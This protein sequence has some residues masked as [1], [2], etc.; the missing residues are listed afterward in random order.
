MAD[1]KSTRREE[2]VLF[3]EGKV[4]VIIELISFRHFEER[5]FRLMDFFTLAM[6]EIERAIWSHPLPKMRFLFLAIDY[7]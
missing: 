3:D 6:G 4:I 5:S 2:L 1:K 7:S